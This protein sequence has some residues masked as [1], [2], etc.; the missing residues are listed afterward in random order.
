MEMT[1]KKVGN[2]GVVSLTGRM[3][4]Y[5]SNKVSEFLDGL[6]VGD[7]DLLVEM[8]GVD[9]MSSSGL[10]VMLSS[11]KKLNKTGGSL[12]LCSLQPYVMEVFEIAGFN[13][14]FEIYDNENE[15]LESYN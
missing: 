10:R 5:N 4:A 14:L 11:L 6:I 1:K 3:D 8:D 12:K 13:Q 7:C 2:V 9:Y 15:A